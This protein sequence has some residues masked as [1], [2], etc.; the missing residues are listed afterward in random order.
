ML[1]RTCAMQKIKIVNPLTDLR[2]S[3]DHSPQA[4]TLQ[5]T[6]YLFL[7]LERIWGRSRRQQLHVT[8]PQL[9][10]VSFLKNSSNYS[11]KFYITRNYIQSIGYILV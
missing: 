3:A 5:S 10:D 8:R 1:A 6:A 11:H 7:A 9:F 4:Y 2:Y